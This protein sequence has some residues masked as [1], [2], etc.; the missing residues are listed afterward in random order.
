MDYL[1]LEDLAKELADLNERTD[2]QDSPLDDDE[3]ERLAALVELEGQLFT[4]MADYAS[5]ERTLIP[6]EEF[7]D[8]AQ[9]FAYDVGYASRADENP[10]HQFIDWGGWAESLKADHTEV[11]FDG[12]TYLI[13]A[14]LERRP[15][16]RT[17]TLTM[18]I[19]TD[20]EDEATLERVIRTALDSMALEPYTDYSD[21]VLEPADEG[22]GP[23]D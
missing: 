3:K 22:R 11:T 9:D 10:L 4:D 14:A 19:E 12:A 5:N 16:M 13:R 15:D 17:F 21:L 18:A 1:D 2:S 23:Q 20:I 8:Y 6:E 7:Q